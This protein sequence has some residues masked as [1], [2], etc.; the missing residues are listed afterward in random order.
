MRLLREIE[1]W[2]E[3][4]K[5][6]KQGVIIQPGIGE[7]RTVGGCNRGGKEN[8]ARWTQSWEIRKSRKDRVKGSKN[9]NE[10]LDKEDATVNIFVDVIVTVIVVVFVFVCLSL[11]EG[12]KKI[13]SF[14]RL[15]LLSISLQHFLTDSFGIWA[16]YATR[17]RRCNARW[18][19]KSSQQR[20]KKCT[21]C[22]LNKIQIYF[23]MDV[24]FCICK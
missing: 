2:L 16:T 14:S 20:G 10:Q 6:F 24:K 7:R 13:G 1:D 22:I 8:T 15:L 11:R 3:W 4:P 12:C 21:K 19:N 18:G 23:V 5:K 9:G 17:Q